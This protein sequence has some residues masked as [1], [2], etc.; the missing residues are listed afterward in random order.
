V[1]GA[2]LWTLALTVLG[3]GLGLLWLWLAPRVPLFSDGKAVFLKDPEGEEAIGADGTFVLLALAFGAVTGLLAFARDRGGGVGRVIGMT[4]GAVAG[5][6]LA[7]RLGVWLGP[8]TDVVAAAKAVGAG[9]TFDGPLKLQAPGALLAWPF[10]A[11][12]VY[13]V[14]LG[15]FGRRDVPGGPPVP[16]LRAAP[17]GG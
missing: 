17:D 11:I 8:T 14:L 9:K 5:S 3:V 13:V 6:V 15:L 16:P 4:V 10:A 2:V 12:F 1:L 7:W